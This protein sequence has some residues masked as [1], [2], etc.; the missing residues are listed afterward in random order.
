MPNIVENDR[1]ARPESDVYARLTEAQ[2]RNRLEPEK[3]IFIAESPKVIRR[4][5]DAGCEPLSF[6]M[7]CRH[8]T[9]QTRDII[10]RCD[11]LP[12]YTA[13]SDVLAALTGYQMTRGILCASYADSINGISVSFQLGAPPFPRKLQRVPTHQA[14]VPAPSAGYKLPKTP[15]PQP[16][17]CFGD[18]HRNAS[19]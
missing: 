10:A 3:G 2:L 1:L 9:G 4:A 12:V 19:A 5:L 15:F 8:I 18:F 6:L 16:R 14:N 17:S 7:E 13:D 11:D